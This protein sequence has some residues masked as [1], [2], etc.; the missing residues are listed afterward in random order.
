MN[1]FVQLGSPSHMCLSILFH[2]TSQQL[3]IN[4]LQQQYNVKTFLDLEI[5]EIL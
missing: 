5:A 1:Y 4:R 3:Q 2:E